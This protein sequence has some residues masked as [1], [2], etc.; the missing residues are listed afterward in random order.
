MFILTHTADVGDLPSQTL[1]VLPLSNTSVN[2]RGWAWGLVTW[3]SQCR[4][5]RR[6]QGANGGGAGW[7]RGGDRGYEPTVECE[8]SKRKTR[9][10]STVE[11]QKGYI[12]FSVL[13]PSDLDLL[14][15]SFTHS[16]K[17]KKSV[18]TVRPGTMLSTGH[19]IVDKIMH[20]SLSKSGHL[21]SQRRMSPI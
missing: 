10:V 21:W 8:G 4:E 2:N 15:H 19:T 14:V 11:K 20:V 7:G 16:S 1:A 5:T 6:R 13:F 17:K 3:R 12:H 9:T 18:S